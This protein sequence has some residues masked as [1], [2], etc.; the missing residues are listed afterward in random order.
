MSLSWEISHPEKLVIVVGEGDVTLAD[1][2]VYLDAIVTADAMPYAKL[3]DATRLVPRHDDHDVMMLAARI[4]AYVETLKGGP[5]AFV[6]TNA[7]TRET[8][9]RYINLANKAERPVDIFKSRD[10][11]RAWLATQPRGD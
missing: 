8:I 10:E 11:A 1:V 7:A 9:S 5:L 4:N 6:S 2:E 3:F